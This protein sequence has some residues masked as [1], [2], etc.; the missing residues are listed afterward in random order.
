M[1]SNDTDSVSTGALV[2]IAFGILF[3]WLP[4]LGGV[5]DLEVLIG[6]LVAG[7]LVGGVERG[8]AAGTLGGLAVGGVWGMLALL[9]GDVVGA[10][11]ITLL[12]AGNGLVGGAVGGWLGS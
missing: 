1:A 12:F 7:W 9:L 8:A 2:V 6:G 3:V 11:T 5:V 4:L 10:I